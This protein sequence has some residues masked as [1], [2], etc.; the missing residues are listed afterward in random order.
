[1]MDDF[2]YLP[3]EYRYISGE[4]FALREAHICQERILPYC[5]AV[6]VIEGEY[7]VWIE[8]EEIVL[9]SGKTI[10][11]PYHVKHDV[12]MKGRGIIS[13]AHFNCQF[14]T[15]DIFG[16]QNEKYILSS[17]IKVQELLNEL[18][19][20][21]GSSEIINKISRD[22]IIA[23]IVLLLFY[24]SELCESGVWFEEWLYRALNYIKCNLGRSL[25]VEEVI[26]ETGLKKTI[27]YKKFKEKMQV[28]PHE[29]IISEKMRYAAE[30]LLKGTSVKQ[31]A[32]GVGFYDDVYFGKIFKRE[33]GVT[34][35]GYKRLNNSREFKA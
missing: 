23:E 35:S 17:D 27:F 21:S 10:V 16:F 8:D 25:S 15:R 33:Y 22:K 5:V 2:K 18:N 30:L 32:E 12:G 31:A 26:T 7:F 19:R 34:P 9:T 11:I 6:S 3:V 29:Y 1:M 28:S 14:A 24:E 13:Y 20:I 4:T